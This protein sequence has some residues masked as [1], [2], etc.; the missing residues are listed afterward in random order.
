MRHR[1]ALLD[2]RH[3]MFLA[4]PLAP[5]RQR[6]ALE[7]QRVLEALLAA[8]VLVIRILDSARAQHLVRQIVHVLE[9]QQTRHQP[10]ST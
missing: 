5:A 8:E 1:Q 10:K 2:Q 7:R 4:E 3:E 9:D 6:G